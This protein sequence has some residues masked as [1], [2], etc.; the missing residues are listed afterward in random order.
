MPHQTPLIATIIG[1]IVLAFVL[2]AIANRLRVS[3]I[4][5]YVLAGVVVGPHTPGFVADQALARELAEIGVILLMFGVGLHFSFKDLLSVRRIA[6]PGALAGISVGIVLGLVVS[7]LIG[8]SI[9]AGVVFG[10][11]LSVASTVVL[12]RGLQERRELT[13]ERGR[14]AVGWLVVEDLVMILALVLMPALAA[15]GG[16]PDA[17]IADPTPGSSGTGSVLAALG[18]TIGKVVGLIVAMLVIG[19]RIVPWALHHIAQ[20]GSRELFR[21]A[22]LTIALGM[23]FG[24]AALFDVSFALGAFLAGMILSE[25]ELSQRAA[26]ETLPLRDAFAVLFFVSVGML[27]DPAII[28]REP[29][30][31]VATVLIIL[32]G[33]PLAA[34]LVARWF[35]HPPAMALKLAASLGQIGEFSFIFV[36]LAVALGVLPIDGRDYVLAG[37]IL[38]ILFN[39]LLYLGAGKLGVWLERRKAAA[40]ST[41]MEESTAAPGLK[42]TALRD[43]A[44]V[45]GGGRVGRIIVDELGRQGAPFLV[46]DDSSSVVETL[47]ARGV[48]VI[49]GNAVDADVLG[50]A[51][52]S[53]A[54]QIFVGIP[55]AFEAG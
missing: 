46:I 23:A 11:S 25:S 12:T 29:G 54:K 49:A 16:S 4:V 6:V 41:S 28:V 47:E 3:P 27:I 38:S 26:E 51:N 35:K 34:Y 44:V 13:S 48:E 19:R 45:V 22:V 55:N 42:P 40:S 9:G 24:A 1:G 2:G 14:I 39:P 36:G 31:V 21:L 7:Q 30:P 15:I 17:S 53:Q 43:H 5:G 32:F 52:V 37:A 10:V 8:W 33:K 18:I 20:S 50:A